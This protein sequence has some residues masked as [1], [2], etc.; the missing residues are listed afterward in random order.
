MIDQNVVRLIADAG[1]IGPGDVVIEVGPGT[2]TLTEELLGRA[3]KVVAV[4]IDRDLVK[5][6]KE[7][8][9]ENS[10]LQIIEGEWGVF[11]REGDEAVFR[12]VRRGA[13]VG[14]D[15]LVLAGLEPD[16]EVA[17]AG[18]YLLRPLWMKRMGGGEEHAH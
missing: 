16:S 5:L 8:F 11:V 17:T 13:E 15:V 9:E 4:E 6:L 10:K 1:Q 14:G 18:A 12:R 3:G 2:G 7:R